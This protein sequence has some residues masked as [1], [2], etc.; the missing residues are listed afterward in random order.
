MADEPDLFEPIKRVY[1][2]RLAALGWVRVLVESYPG[3][4]GWTSPAGEV[5]TEDEA[6]DRLEK[7]NRAGRSPDA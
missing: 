3:G 6:F 4:V 2:E 7:A 5:V 1:R